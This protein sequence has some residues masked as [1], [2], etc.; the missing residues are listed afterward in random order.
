MLNR[1]EATWLNDG[2][3]HP[4]HWSSDREPGLRL[5]MLWL[6]I[7]VPL[8]AVAIRMGQLQIVLRDDFARGFDKPRVVQESFSARNGRI[9]AADG[10]VLADDE[11]KYDLQIHYRLIQDPVDE[12]WL[13][14]EALRGLNRVEWKDKLLVAQEMERVRQRHQELWAAI[15]QLTGRAATRNL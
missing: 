13:R 14:S 2:A 12:R 1:P 5:A 4:N 11:E 15:S 3:N 10:S 7:A 6:G 9:L 8:L